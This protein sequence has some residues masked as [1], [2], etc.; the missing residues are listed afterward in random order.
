M[1]HFFLSILFV[2]LLSCSRDDDSTS[3]NQPPRAFTLTT[4]ANNA[5]NVALSPALGWQSATDPDEDAV[6][7]SVYLDQNSNPSTKIIDGLTATSF[8]P[9]AALTNNTTYYWKVIATDTK[10]A[11]T[12]SSV[13]K[14]TTLTAIPATVSLPVK[15]TY[16]NASGA[17]HRTS[18]ISYDAQKRANKVIL[19]DQNTSLNET[20]TFSYDNGKITMTQTFPNDPNATTDKYIYHYNANGMQKEEAFYNNVLK[21][22][23]EW[24]YRADGGKERRVR[25]TSNE[26]IETWYYRFSATGNIER[27]VCDR[28]HSAHEDFEYTFASYD[29]KLRSSVGTQVV[30]VVPHIILGFNGTNLPAPNNPLSYTKK[31]ITS[32]AVL[33]NYVIEYTYNSKNQVTLITLK[34]PANGAVIQTRTIEYQEF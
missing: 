22:T 16:K 9:T 26:L 14:F 13:Y 27:A 17:V 7:Y 19:V 4:P 30:Y 31:S 29:N 21:Y 23:Y 11:T 2:S 28:T 24:H 20:Q 8:T 15:V 6:T 25:D 5:S 12:A 18:T 3:N 1:R 34:N 32:G 33:E 10:G